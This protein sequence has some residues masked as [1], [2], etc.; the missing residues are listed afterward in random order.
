MASSDRGSVRP[1]TGLFYRR[2]PPQP[3]A[4]HRKEW[5]K[6]KETLYQVYRIEAMLT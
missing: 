3:Y 5:I 6:E 1:P 4:T 2:R